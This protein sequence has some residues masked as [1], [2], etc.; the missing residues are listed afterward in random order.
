MPK[1]KAA[2]VGDGGSPAMPAGASSFPRDPMNGNQM[3]ENPEPPM[4]GS[5]DMGNPEDG[6]NEPGGMEGP[7]DMD[8]SMEGD[9][10]S[11]MDIINRLSDTDREA[12][13]AYAESMLAR[14]ETEDGME[15][16]EEPDD[17]GGE[18]TQGPD[19]GNGQM[20]ETFKF[21]KKQLEEMAKRRKK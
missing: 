6:M 13:R 11:T 16:G 21:S 10:D 4:G 8:N 9:G 2:P 14:D 12:V 18:P 19:N 5:P 1:Q 7:E 17:M 15:D 3:P 20:F